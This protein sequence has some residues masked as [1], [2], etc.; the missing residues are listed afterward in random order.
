M[1][2]LVLP[3]LI[4]ALTIGFG[5]K[6]IQN[7]FQDKS[8]VGKWRPVKG[9]DPKTGK[10]EDEKRHSDSEKDYLMEFFSNGD[11]GFNLFGLDTS[12][13]YKSDTSTTPNRIILTDKKTGKE[14]VWIYKFQGKNLIIKFPIEEKY[15][16][17]K[18]FSLEPN[19]AIWE[20]ERK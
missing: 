2:N 5:C 19:F 1:K 7:I 20:L 17:A 15:G 9:Y 14:S 13:T 10:W 11:Y 3:I 18:D 16:I 4:I 6:N 8:L 12:R